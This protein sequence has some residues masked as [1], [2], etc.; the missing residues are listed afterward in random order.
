MYIHQ[1]VCISPQLTFPEINLE[2]IIPSVDNMLTVIEPKHENIPMS[3]LRRMGKAVRMGVSASKALLK[4]TEQADGVIIGTANGG[5]E[6]CIKFLN[7]II[8][9]NEGTLT[10]KNFVQSTANAI[11]GQIA[12]TVANKGY[13]IT[14]V[15][16]GLSFENAMLDAMMLLRENPKST[17]LLG[18]LDEISTYNYNIESVGGWYKDENISNEDLYNADT[19]GSIAGEGVA[20]FIASNKP[21]QALAKIKALKTLHS[22]DEEEIKSQL[23]IFIENNSG[24]NSPIDLL[25]SGENG[26]NRL[27]H[28]YNSCEGLFNDL[29]PIARFKHLCGEYPTAS[30]FALWL[31]CLM[32]NS[33]Q[34]PLRV[35]KNHTNKKELKTILIYNNYKGL[36]H[37]FMLVEKV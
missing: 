3:I 15:L 27:N 16:R 35:F 1:S 30:A 23:K 9:Y 11:A 7:Q 34:L 8:D 31:A 12:L 4:D 6:D 19:K 20:M 21:E 22:D 10:P 25:M 5:M 17:Y 33:E 37:S 18:G 2:Q 28:F 13:N 29:L 36:Q 14:H 26:D 32:L 24:D